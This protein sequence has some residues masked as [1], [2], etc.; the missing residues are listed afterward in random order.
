LNVFHKLRFPMMTGLAAVLVLISGCSMNPKQTK[1][2]VTDVPLGAEEHFEG[3]VKI[4]TNDSVQVFSLDDQIPVA[5]GAPDQIADMQ[6]AVQS[7]PPSMMTGED[8]MMQPPQALAAPMPDAPAPVTPLNAQG[9]PYGKAG[10]VEIFPFDDQTNVGNLPATDALMPQLPPPSGAA[11]QFA[12]PFTDNGWNA[13]KADSNKI[14]FRNGSSRLT[15]SAQDVLDQIAANAASGQLVRV[16]GH[17]SKRAASKD[18]V[19]RHLVN[20]KMSMQRAV[21][22]S[23]TLIK[24]GVPAASI[25]TTAWGDTQPPLLTDP[26]MDEE[27]AAR[28]VE[29]FTQPK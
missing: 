3:T 22:V 9:V 1:P 15:G 7:P 5:P 25:K 8:D 19:R 10:N 23:Q 6:P 11:G 26:G 20:L 14:F 21:N 18:P 12:S 13:D 2:I 28:R 4:P 17:A 16:E 27:S 24:K 29:I